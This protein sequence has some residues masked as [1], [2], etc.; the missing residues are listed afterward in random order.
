MYF[1]YGTITLSDVG[2]QQL[3]LYKHFLTL[4][5]KRRYCLTTPREIATSKLLQNLEI[6]IS[7]GLGCSRFARRYLGNVTTYVALFSFPPGTEM[8]HFPGFAHSSLTDKHDR[9]VLYRVSP[10]RYL[11]IKG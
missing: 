11:R 1:E 6:I 9:G 4:L 10:F 2:F 3:L 7:R 5:V 8:F